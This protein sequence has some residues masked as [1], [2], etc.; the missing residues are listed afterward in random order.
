M[1]VWEQY[2]EGKYLSFFLT[3]MLICLAFVAVSSFYKAGVCQQESAQ[4]LRT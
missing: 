3:L 1:C 4:R 2:P